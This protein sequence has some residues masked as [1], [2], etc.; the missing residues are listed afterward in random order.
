MNIISIQA[1]IEGLEKRKVELQERL[2]RKMEEFIDQLPLIAEPWIK[3][4]VRRLIE[5]NP[6]QAQEMGTKQLSELKQ[7]MNSLISQLPELSNMFKAVRKNK[8][9]R[10]GWFLQKGAGPDFASCIREVVT[11][12]LCALLNEFGLPKEELG[13]FPTIIGKFRYRG[14]E[15]VAV[16]EYEDIEKK[17]ENLYLE[18]RNKRMELEKAKAIEL[19]DAAR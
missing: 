9:Q 6:K 11:N 4:E 5:E 16:N 19:W 3:T 13:R 8:P 14:I 12:H 2:D 17:C 1:E 7:K 15:I 18:M 10:I